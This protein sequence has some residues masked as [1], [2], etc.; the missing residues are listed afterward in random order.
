MR[1]F[2][3]VLVLVL[4]LLTPEAPAR[5]PT[6]GM[7]QRAFDAM[8]EAQESMDAGNPDGAL[9]ILDK[10]LERR[11]SAYE[12]AQML[13]MKGMIDYQADR[14]EDA[15][16]A[17][18][19]ALEQERLPEALRGDLIGILG[20]LALMADDNEV[21]ETYFLELLGIEGQDLPEN[22]I[23]LA[24]AYLRQEKYGA[25]LAPIEAAIAAERSLGRE[26]KEQWLLMLASVHHAREDLE[27]MR[28]VM[29]ELTL[30]YPREQHL[31]NLAA[32]HGQLGDRQRQL[33][34]V[35][36]LLDEDRLEG[37]SNLRMLAGLF[38][39][40]ELP[41]KAARVLEQGIASG[42][43]DEDGR[44]LEQLSQAWFQA[45]EIDRAIATLDAAAELDEQGELFLRLAGL[46]M[47]A[48]RWE[49]AERSAARAL[50][51]GSLDD[52]GRAWLIL[53]MARVRLEQF[54]SAEDSFRNARRFE[55]SRTYADQW[56]AFVE[57]EQEIRAVGR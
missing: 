38:M 30:L 53:G 55:D 47:D 5:A 2:L 56:L 29:R 17:F 48:Y 31:M 51:L 39:A 25:A 32:L 6:Y 19:E 13:R 35:E 11:L 57:N 7:S 16:G 52:E 46:Q 21:A 34:L 49:D 1:A 15:R 44:T 26:P 23:L 54:A 8:E 27:T 3:P 28:A 4:V 14:L 10:A 24:N 18:A 45:N 50:E 12:T 40:E 42:R 22:R 33:A 20:R 43:L 41:F 37:D 9:A 36:S